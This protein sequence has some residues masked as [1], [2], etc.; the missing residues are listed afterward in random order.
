MPS[1]ES[2][3]RSCLTIILAAGEGT[4]MKSSR[5][6]VLHEVAGRAMVSH[7]VAA[8]VGAGA[9]AIAVVV[10]PGREDVGVEARR[11]APEAQVFTQTER[12]GTAHAT[13]AARTALAQG[14]DDVLVV[15]GDT[16]LLTPESLKALRA[17]LAQ[18]AQVAALG[19]E[20]ADPT[21]YGRLI[22]E[23]GELRAIREQKDASEAERAVR[24]CNAGI[25]ALQGREAPA[26]LDSIGSDN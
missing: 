8:C 4:R 21:G 11:L 6:K 10:G 24:L 12:L 17:A 1:A 18:G 9:D 20:P 3:D 16:P 19:F 15:F 14:Y 26:L 13:L 23:G 2:A 5:P 7:V 22:L 25:M